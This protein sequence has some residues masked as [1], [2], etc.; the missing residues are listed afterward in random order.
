MSSSGD[1]PNTTE[2]CALKLIE[3]RSYANYRARLVAANRLQARSMVWNSVLVGMSA[4]TTIASI[5]LLVNPD[6]FGMHSS[7]L[8]SVTSVLTLV[9]SLIVTSRDYSARARDMTSNY[10]KSQ[11]IASEAELARISDSAASSSAELNNRYNSLLDESEN[12]TSADYYRSIKSNPECRTDFS[13]LLS[14]Y[15]Q[16]FLTYSP[17]ILAFIPVYFIIVVLGWAI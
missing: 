3:D 8:F 17:L 13:R 10:R 14:I 7:L 11:R 2:A 1:E 6:L 15:R 16:D 12:H 9:T 5:G 4:S